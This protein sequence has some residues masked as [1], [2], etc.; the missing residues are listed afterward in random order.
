VIEFVLALMTIVD[1][2]PT[3]PS[4]PS[5]PTGLNTAPVYGFY[6]FY[7]TSTDPSAYTNFYADGVLK[8]TL[9][10]GVSQVVSNY[11]PYGPV[12]TFGVKHSKNGLLSS[13][14]TIQRIAT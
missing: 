6:G 1:A 2:A 11:R 4:P 14:T 5:A 10:P 12:I 13:E 7:W 8:T 9:P 3:P